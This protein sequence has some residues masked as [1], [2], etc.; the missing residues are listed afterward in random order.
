LEHAERAYLERVKL[1][2]EQQA[3][4]SVGVLL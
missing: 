1:Y 4:A 2:N 3:A